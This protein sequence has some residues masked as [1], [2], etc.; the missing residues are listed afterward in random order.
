MFGYSHVSRFFFFF[1]SV[2]IFVVV[3][4]R[5]FSHC[6]V[7]RLRTCATVSPHLCCP[8]YKCSVTQHVCC[9]TYKCSVNP[10]LCCQTYNSSVTPHL[11]CHT[12][13]CSVTPH[14]C[15]HTYKCSV[16]PHLCCHT[17]KCSVIRHS[18]SHTPSSGMVCLVTVSNVLSTAQGHLEENSYMVAFSLLGR[19]L[20]QCSN[21]S[22]PACAF[23]LLLLLLFFFFFN[24]D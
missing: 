16:T 2:E 3:L 22:L 15:C 6:W 14:L 18:G 10:H 9:H 11:C 5:R 23:L 13:K 17:Y 4:I 21:T 7:R 19:L 24:G 20:R 1:L 12:Y 8:T